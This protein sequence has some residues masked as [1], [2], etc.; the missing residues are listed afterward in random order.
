MLVAVPTGNASN[1]HLSGPISY[2]L[3]TSGC[4][5]WQAV[6]RDGRIINEWET[7]SEPS[8]PIAKK[9][10]ESQWESIPKRG[11]IA[12]RLLCPNGQAAGLEGDSDGI[13]FQLKIAVR[14]VAPLPCPQCKGK[15]VPDVRRGVRLIVRHGAT[16]CE[17]CEGSGFLSSTRME[18]AHLIGIVTDSNAAVCNAWEHEPHRFA[19]L[20]HFDPTIDPTMK[21]CAICRL[22]W[23]SCG[24]T[25]LMRRQLVSFADTLHPMHYRN[26]GDIVLPNVGL[27]SSA[28]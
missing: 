14:L 7:T 22:P 26:V 10:S 1:L 20:T 28:I 6:Y 4:S 16:V 9:R 5:W 15:G 27:I 18:E 21:V 24:G 2:A 19:P 3:Q 17:D 25:T 12:L 8:R 11:M 13:F 23:E